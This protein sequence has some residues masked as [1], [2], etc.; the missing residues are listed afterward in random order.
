[1]SLLKK[2]NFERLER[3]KNSSFVVEKGSIKL[4]C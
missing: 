1:M 2:D 4:G 3:R